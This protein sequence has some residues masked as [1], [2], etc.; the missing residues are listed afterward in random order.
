MKWSRFFE[1]GNVLH[2]IKTL[3]RGK[4]NSGGIEDDDRELL[5]S[6][7]KTSSKYIIP[8]EMG[9]G[10]CFNI[11]NRIRFTNGR[12]LSKYWCAFYPSSN[13][14]KRIKHTM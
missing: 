6:S 10:V 8:R 4:V 2:R 14:Q 9:H 5:K 3:F 1:S 7:N 11:E 12:Q 13:A